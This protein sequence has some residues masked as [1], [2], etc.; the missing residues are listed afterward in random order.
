MIC[1]NLPCAQSPRNVLLSECV[2]TVLEMLTLKVF[3][4]LWKHASNRVYVA[5]GLK[6]NPNVCVLISDL[7]WI[8]I[9][10]LGEACKLLQ[11]GNRNRS[12]AATKLNQSSSRR[13][14]FFIS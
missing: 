7:R 6:L 8:N 3:F 2:T 11:F 10:N 13:Q 12:A 1:F 5:Q 4:S 9:Q 14:T